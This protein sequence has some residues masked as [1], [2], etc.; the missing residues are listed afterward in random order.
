MSRHRE[1]GV[2]LVAAAVALALLSALATSLAWTST[3]DQRLARNAL[4]ALQADALV[5]SGVAA[6]AVVLR[7]ASAAGLLDTLRAPWAQPSGAQ[8]LGAGTVE[9]TIE[10]EARRLD[11]NTFPGTL[12]RLLGALGLDPRLAETLA[13]WTDLDDAPRPGGAERDWYLALPHPY[14]PR[15]A[16]LRTVG[17]L[18]LVRGFDRATV[19]RLR[20]FVTV[21]GE[22][23][24]NP[25]TAPREVLLALTGSPSTVERLLATRSGRALGRADFA[26]LLPGVPGERLC[27]RATAYTVRA[28]ATVSE[29]RRAAAAT[30]WVPAG[31]GVDPQVVAWL[32]LA[33]D[34]ATR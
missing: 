34:A 28:V 9:V 25:N 20:P 18:G 30:L 7:E 14:L 21:A 15:N 12:P 29:M 27:E 3:I 8:P 19:E 17:E 4:A 24:V 26:A 10:D 13:D 32:P 5:R 6:A 33:N 11:L 31:T 22:R 23:A 2:A 16:A 1:R